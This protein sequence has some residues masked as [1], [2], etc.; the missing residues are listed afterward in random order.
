M[1]AQKGV[2]FG[3]VVNPNGPKAWKAEA[4]TNKATNGGFATTICT[5]EIYGTGQAPYFNLVAP[6]TRNHSGA[7]LEQHHATLFA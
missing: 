7:L 5:C 4:A 6:Q 1:S 3:A 2:A